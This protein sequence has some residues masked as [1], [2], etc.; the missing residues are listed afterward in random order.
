MCSQNPD[1]V[2]KVAISFLFI[3]TVLPASALPVGQAN[4]PG[5]DLNSLIDALQNKYSKMGG[6][7]ADFAQVYQGH[8]GRILRERGHVILKRPSKARWDYSSPEP[9]LFVSDGKNVFFYVPGEK[10][11]TRASIKQSADPQI[12]FLF[13]LG[14]GNL[15]RDF[16]RI[17]VVSS[18]RPI[19]GGDVVLKLVPKRAPAEFKQILVEVQVNPVAVRRLV[20]FERNGSRMDFL[21]SNVRENAIAADSRFQFVP[22][23]GVEIVNAR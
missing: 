4:G 15:R 16:S 14:R 3:L 21:L 13:L 2:R 9:K 23:P 18:E 5:V 17:E 12:P 8:D 20:I 7:E 19:G 6:L 10:H 1:L 22:P 11:A